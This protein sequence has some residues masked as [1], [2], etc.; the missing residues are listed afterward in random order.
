MMAA[1]VTDMTAHAGTITG[2][3][4]PTVLIGKMPA[5]R[6]GDMHMCPMVTPGVP[7]VPHVGGPIVGGCPTVLIGKLPAARQGDMCVCVGP[8]SSIVLGCPTVLIGSGGGGGGGGGGASAAS[9]DTAKALKEGKI[10]P[11]E[12]TETFPVEIQ[13]A[14]SEMNKYCAPEEVQ[15]KVKEIGEALA[16]AGEQQKKEPLTIKDIVEVLKE[17]EKEEGYEAARHFASHLD[18][19]KLTDIAKAFVSG[20]NSDPD[21][22][23]NRMPT[24]FMLL[25]GMDD[26]Q[27]KEI[28]DHPD[29][30][31]GEEHKINVKNLRRG[32]KFLGYDVKNDGPFDD[33]VWIGF[34]QHLASLPVQKKFEETHIV[35]MGEDL[36]SI[37]TDYGIT[38][39]KYL[40]EVNKGA[41]GDNP[42]LLKPGTELTIPQWD[43]TQGDEKIQ[44]K[45]GGLNVYVN[46]LQ[47]LYVWVPLS[48]SF[49]DSDAAKGYCRD[50]E[51]DNENES[52][53]MH[54]ELYDLRQDKIILEK[55]IEGYDKLATLI[56]EIADAEIRVDGRKVV[57]KGRV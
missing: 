33:E 17:V 30:F 22:D 1:R 27:I 36:G 54:V 19:G 15:Q 13:A 47:Y 18:Y 8:P 11:V 48:I 35:E 53:I 44:A 25:Y 3:G 50:S 29:C 31:D 32:L 7:P 56:P 37:A 26:S 43:D 20:K 55:E 49:F 45:G 41:I 38:S 9:A 23:P 24:R 5:A 6:M 39:W 51:N 42:D 28:D 57:R 21:N 52:Q 14:L 10:K 12:G 2:P 4:C 34:V 46:G 16:A 40:Y